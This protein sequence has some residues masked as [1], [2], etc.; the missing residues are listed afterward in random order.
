MD[1]A[2]GAI[3][4]GVYTVLAADA[5]LLALV[6]GVYD[7]VPDSTAAKRYVHIGEAFESP[8][9]TF[10]GNGH[11]VMLTVHS[12]TEDNNEQR[13]NARAQAINSRVIALLHGVAITVAGHTLV[14]CEFDNTQQLPRDGAWR[15]LATEF[16]VL[17]E[18]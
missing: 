6:D 8:T 5:T 13:G 15:H 11:D 4:T 12:Y 1:S 10:G 14:T 9:P 17:V 7:A 18:D 2:L 16:R 3:Q